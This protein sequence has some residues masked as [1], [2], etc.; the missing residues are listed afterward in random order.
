VSIAVIA[1][2]AQPAFAAW[3]VSTIANHGNSDSPT[4][5][6]LVSPTGRTF[7]TWVTQGSDELH[8]GKQTASGWRDTIVT[9]ANTFVACYDVSYD[10]VGPAATFLPNGDAAIASACESFSGGSKTMFSELTSTGW[11]TTKVGLGPS[12][13]Q[14]ATS[15]TD[16]ELVVSPKGKPVILTTDGCLGGIYGFFRTA[17]GWKKKWVVKGGGCCGQFRYGAMA[18]AIDPT[19]GMIA[20]VTNGDVYGR[21]SIGVEEFAWNGD[22]V[23]GS[24]HNFILPNG[25]VPYGEPSLA[26]ANDGTAYLAFQ[27]GTPPGT[28]LG[29]AYSFLAMSTRSAS[30]WGTPA[31][32]DSAV[33]FTGGEPDLSLAGGSFHIAYYDSM[34]KDL[35]FATSPDGT[36]WTLS[37]IASAGDSGNY[38]SLAITAT[39][40]VRIAFYHKSDTSLRAIVGP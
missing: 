8:W 6:I 32:I 29:S 15:A 19:N 38:P 39:G 4:S 10:G 23:I 7:A 17:T 33:Q 11:T 20:V 18:T 24:T 13:S 14:C 36:T 25:D 34:N 16:V 28:A 35:R 26:F 31:S 27:E 12:S 3:D 5:R 22:P 37:T 40:G 30:V 9:G 21:S 1:A 2:F